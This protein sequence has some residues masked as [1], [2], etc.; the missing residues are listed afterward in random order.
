MRFTVRRLMIA[1]AGLAWAF[2][3]VTCG[4]RKTENRFV[5]ENRS[6]QTLASLQIS[7]ST[8]L[9]RILRDFQ[10]RSLLVIVTYGDGRRVGRVV[11]IPHRD[12]T[13]AVSLEF[14]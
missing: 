6:G 2:G 1:V 10:F 9:G 4:L 7:L 13:R 12:L 3:G 5:V 14:Q 8:G 11:T